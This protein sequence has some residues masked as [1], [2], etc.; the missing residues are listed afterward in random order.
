MSE[1]ALELSTEFL[2]IAACPACHAKFAVDYER[3][4][5]VCTLMA[6][7]GAAEKSPVDGEA[8]E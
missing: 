1:T 7:I 5:L 6:G 4:E 8:E 3:S 2:A